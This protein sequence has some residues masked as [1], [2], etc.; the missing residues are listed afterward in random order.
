MEFALASLAYERA[1]QTTAYRALHR[2]E[3]WPLDRIYA[4]WL[5]LPPADR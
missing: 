5:G 2:P 4:A 3:G 1:G